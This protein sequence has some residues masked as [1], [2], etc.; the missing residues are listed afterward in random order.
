MGSLAFLLAFRAAGELPYRPLCPPYLLGDETDIK[1]QSSH[2]EGGQCALEQARSSY[3]IQLRDAAFATKMLWIVATRYYAPRRWEA[4]ASLF[5][6]LTQLECFAAF[7]GCFPGGVEQEAVT[8][9]P[10]CIAFRQEAQTVFKLDAY[11]RDATIQLGKDF[12]RS[13]EDLIALKHPCF[14]TDDLANFV[15]HDMFR[16]QALLPASN[17]FG[18]YEGP[19][20]GLPGLENPQLRAFWMP[21]WTAPEMHT[22][23]AC[24]AKGSLKWYSS[25]EPPIIPDSLPAEW[26]AKWVAN[27]GAGDGTCAQDIV[28]QDNLERGFLGY[29]DPANC[30]VRKGYGGV[31]FE[32]DSQHQPALEEMLV[33]RTDLELGI[34]FVDPRMAAQRI[35]EFRDARAPKS[36]PQLLKVDVDNCDCCFV[37]AILAAGLRPLMIHVEVSPLVPP[38]IIYRPAEFNADVEDSMESLSASEGRPGHMRHCSLSAFMELLDGF[39]YHLVYFAYHDA[40]FAQR[41][42]QPPAWLVDRTSSEIWMGAYFCHPLRWV[43]PLEILYKEKFLYDY[44]QWSDLAVPVPER[45]RRVQRYLDNWLVPRSSYHLGGISSRRCRFCT[46]ARARGAAK[47]PLHQGQVAGEKVAV[48]SQIRDCANVI[49]SFVR[50]YAALGF[51]RMLLYL[52]DPED[53]AAAVLQESGWVQNGFVELVVINDALRAQWPS[54]PSWRRVGQFANMEVQSRQIL[55]NEHALVRARQL[56]VDWLLHVD[57]DEL[58]RIAVTW[59]ACRGLGRRWLRGARLAA[60]KVQEQVLLRHARRAARW[61]ADDSLF[62]ALNLDLAAWPQKVDFRRPELR[63]SPLIP[64]LM[65]PR[66]AKKAAGTLGALGELFANCVKIQDTDDQSTAPSEEVSFHEMRQQLLS[67]RVFSQDPMARQQSEP[68]PALSSKPLMRQVSMREPRNRNPKMAPPPMAAWHRGTARMPSANAYRMAMP[69]SELEAL[70]RQAG[71]RTDTR[72]RV[73]W[74]FKSSGTV[75]SLL[76]KVCPENLALIVEKIAAVEVEGREQ[77]EAIIELIFKKAVT[78]PHYSE[79]YADLVFSLKSEFPDFPD[80][81]GGKPVTFRSLVLNICQNEFEELL[82]AAET[83][84]QSAE[85]TAEE[86]DVLAKKRKERMCAN[87][88]FVGHLYLRQL[89]STK[90]VGSIIC[91]LVCLEDDDAFPEEHALECACELLLTAGYTMDTVPAGQGAL[92]LSC[93]RLQDLKSRKENGKSRYCKRIQFMIQDVL[94]TRAAGWTKKVFKATAKTKEELRLSQQREMSER[95]CGKEASIAEHIVTGKRPVYLAA[96]S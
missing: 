21:R 56:G 22:F 46:R 53:S 26:E 65:K 58:P 4:Y 14:E 60:S 42:I 49:E 9:L 96:E 88:K 29:A 30:M 69:Q 83:P 6:T 81:S 64:M 38:P 68:C 50:H 73:G 20:E 84:E 44:R 94:E 43:D 33:N 13:E 1:V 7:R 3:A 76:N 59:L 39:G 63:R 34:G 36:S 57:S 54:M 80:A 24:S 17:L 72:R 67:F 87:M 52:D 25:F 95:A 66:A 8:V 19:L 41:I 23:G 90:V 16:R 10:V 86:K 78:E 18:S 55:N 93:K 85:C 48:F 91:E 47:V 2:P 82:S 89:L 5:E 77:L 92:D 32:G 51:Y 71:S 35:A 15:S 12:L 40:T 62:S 11:L 28:R 74:S 70:K 75:Q 31:L 61:R 45:L 37:E 79:T 27:L